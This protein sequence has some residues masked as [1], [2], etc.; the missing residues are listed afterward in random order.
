MVEK[1]DL[2]EGVSEK[3]AEKFLSRLKKEPIIFQEI[4][5]GYNSVIRIQ[6]SYYEGRELYGLQKFWREDESQDWQYGKAITFSRTS[7]E[8]KIDNVIEGFTKMKAFLEGG[9]S[10]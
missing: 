3:E 9:D 2:P 5:V 7:I 6:K 8:E 4:E 10:E 1:M